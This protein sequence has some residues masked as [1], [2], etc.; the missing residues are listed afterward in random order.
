M[1]L[2][3]LRS[4]WLRV[5][6]GIVA[7]AIAGIAV[8]QGTHLTGWSLFVACGAL[9]G[10]AIAIAVR[11][12]RGN[13]R[14]T[15]VTISVPQFSKLHFAVTRDS[16]QVAWKLFVEVVT[17]VSVQPLDAQTGRLREALTSLYG[18]FATTREMLKESQPSP[19]TGTDPTVEHLA[20]A[21]LNTVLRPFL[22]RWHPALLVW[23]TAHPGGDERG[24][25]HDVACRSD[26][27]A[28]Q[29][30]L[31]AYVTSFGK[32]AGVP[33]ATQIIAGTLGDQSAADADQ[34]DAGQSAAGQSAADPIPR[35]LDEANS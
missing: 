13:V 34:S 17:R 33:N 15:D 27:A 31:L 19:R 20:I 22:S 29:R 7:G 1:S 11:G 8:Y 5:P 12:Y 23:E 25:P 21:M 24:W 9:A 26:L 2:A 16:R 4:W 32:L 3:F 14:L 18:L 35:Q 30:Q 10:T 28:V 6:I